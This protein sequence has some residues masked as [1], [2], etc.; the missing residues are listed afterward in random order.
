VDLGSATISGMTRDGSLLWLA[1]P[2]ERAVAAHDPASG[3]TETR[4][5]YAHEVWDVCPAEDGLWLLTA[6]GK[7]DRQIVFWSFAENQETVRYGCPDGAGSG[8][9]LYDEKLWLPHRHNRKLFCIDPKSGKTNWIVRTQYESF[10]PA[11]Y[12]NELWL[13]E[14]DPGPLGHWNETQARYFVARYDPAREN[15][16]ERLPVP[17]A[18]RCMAPDGDRFWYAA[19][20]E[21]G[22]ASTK[23]NL[24]Q[25]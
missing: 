22:I 20:G 9:A 1:A 11:A 2:E 6:G 8:L 23:K 18:P 24:R 17:F 3:E 14:C 19:E 4:L 7:L 5:V 13:V 15:M 16:I 25:I 10:S 12:K 21:A